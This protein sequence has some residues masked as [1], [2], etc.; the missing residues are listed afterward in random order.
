MAVKN[1]GE[2]YYCKICGNKVMVMEAGGGTLVCCGQEMKLTEEKHQST[3][4][5]ADSGI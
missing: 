5:I 3:I 1:N 2:I 4:N